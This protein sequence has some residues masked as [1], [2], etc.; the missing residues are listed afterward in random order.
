[1]VFTNT[2][3][4]SGTY[5]FNP[6]AGDIIIGAFQRIR[7]RPTEILQ[8]HLQQ[9]II[10]LNLLLVKFSN[11]QPNL[12]GVDLQTVPLVQGTGTYSVP[13]ETVMITNAFIRT[14]SG[15]TSI[16][17]VIFP[18]SQTEYAAIPNK[19]VQGSPNQFWFNRQ[20]SPT[21][22]LYAVPDGNG[23]YTLMYYRVRQVQDAVGSNGYNVEVPYLWLDAITAGLAHRLARIYAPELED[24]R[25]MDADEAWTIAATQNTENVPMYIAPGLIG[26]FS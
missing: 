16:D 17:R 9:A 8:S 15:T 5:N 7:M 3:V 20:I 1:M 12:W 6:S 13:A 19:A 2:A 23:P 14:T 21:I 22:T 18:I 24:R 11:L 25:K 26:Y 10:E 4:Y